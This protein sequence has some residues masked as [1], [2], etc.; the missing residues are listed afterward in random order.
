M[1]HGID[2]SQWQGIITSEQWKDI[3]E[4]CSFVIIRAGYRGYGNGALKLDER[5]THNLGACERYGIPYGFYF[6]TQAINA[7]EAREEAEL[8]ARTVDI[9]KAKYGVWCDTEDSANGQGRA[10]N[11]SREARTEA[12]SAF[13]DAVNEKGGTGGIYA[14][15]YWLKDKLNSGALEKYPIWC[16]CYLNKC[17]YT[18]KNLVLWQYCS[19]NSLK[20]NGFGNSLDCDLLVRDFAL[21][22]LPEKS[23]DELAKEVIAGKW[24]NG[25]ERKN[26]LTAAGYDYNAVQSRVN[27]MLYPKVITYIVKGGDTLSGIAQRYGTTVA[28]LAAENGIKNPNLIY[29]GQKIVINEQ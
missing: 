27:E 17:L 11:I 15:Y 22:K 26:R 18:G 5:L 10:D 12:V 16:P 21:S 28:K 3:R 13:C 4:K 9:T 29:P 7:A 24:G 20:I 6:F 2:I 25:L 1:K 8:I 19:D 23:I 14:G